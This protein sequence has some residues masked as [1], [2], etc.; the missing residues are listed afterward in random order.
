M[1]T[2]FGWRFVSL[3]LGFKFLFFFPFFLCVSM[4][5][6]KGRRELPPGIF[7]IPTYLMFGDCVLNKCCIAA[8]LAKFNQL[9]YGRINL[10][11]NCSLQLSSF[12]TKVIE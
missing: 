5:L 12:R 11:F 2:L 4:Y 10:A 7:F 9:Q 8:Y 6:Q 1:F 3:H